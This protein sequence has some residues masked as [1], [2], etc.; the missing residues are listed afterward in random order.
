MASI[1]ESRVEKLENAMGQQVQPHNMV[2]AF[3]RPGGHTSC[4]K[5]L[6]T[7]ESIE[8]HDGEPD[9]VFTARAASAGF[10]RGHAIGK[11]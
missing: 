9:D 5:R 6:P 7:G 4:F 1:L 8:Q 2:I 11:S 3:V 10:G